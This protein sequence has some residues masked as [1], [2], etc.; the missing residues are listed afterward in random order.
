MKSTQQTAVVLKFKYRWSVHCLGRASRCTPV[1]SVLSGYYFHFQRFMINMARTRI[2]LL[3]KVRQHSKLYI[4]VSKYSPYLFT[5]FLYLNY[6]KIFQTPTDIIICVGF[7]LDLIILEPHHNLAHLLSEDR[8]IYFQKIALYPAIGKISTPQTQ[9]TTA[10]YYRRLFLV[11]ITHLVVGLISL[12]WE[13]LLFLI[14][15]ILSKPYMQRRSLDGEVALQLSQQLP[16]I[17]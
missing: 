5:L 7:L 15:M 13:M 2:A 12:L 10:A 6:P 14:R 16:G 8:V 17:T 9:M 3:D 11:N 1:Q 4:H